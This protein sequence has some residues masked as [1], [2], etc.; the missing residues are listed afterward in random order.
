ME[1][2]SD[3]DKFELPRRTEACRHLYRS[4]R[5][6]LLGNKYW[7]PALGGEFELRI[8]DNSVV[9][10]LS[11][12]LTEHEAECGF[13]R[14]SNLRCHEFR[15]QSDRGTPISSSAVRQLVSSNRALTDI[16]IAILS[17]NHG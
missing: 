5:F 16:W 8:G 2:W 1:E 13:N 3:H 15:L 9:G 6:S 11:R 12:A 7:F 14:G 10:P 4:T 17:S